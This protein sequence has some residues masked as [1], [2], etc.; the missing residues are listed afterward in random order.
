VGR[1]GGSGTGQ[2]LSRDLGVRVSLSGV[3][4]EAFVY[5]KNYIVQGINWQQEAN[6]RSTTEPGLLCYRPP[7]W[8]RFK[9]GPGLLCA[10]INPH[11]RIS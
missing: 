7:S 8:A 3:I 4:R 5:I 11:I 9:G 1:L 10:I 2:T 6:R